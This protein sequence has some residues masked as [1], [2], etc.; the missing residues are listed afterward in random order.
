VEALAHEQFERLE[1]SHWWLRGRRTVYLGLLRHLL[2]G[3]RPG[4]AL[5]VGA[6][7]GGFSLGLAGLCD[8]VVALDRDAA[9]LAR[10]CGRSGARPLLADAAR[11]PFAEASFD[12]VC[13]F[14]VLEH[15]DDDAGA[16]RE[17]RRVLRPGGLLFASVPAWPFLYAHNDRVAHHRRRYRR[18]PLA[19]A[20]EAAGLQ[21]VRNTHTNAL[22]F[23]LI[24]PAVLAVKAWERLRGPRAGPHTNLSWPLP[25]GL[26]EL[27]YRAFAAELP[28]ARRLD[29]PA[30]HSIALAARRPPT[31]RAA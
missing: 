7:P 4:R 13:L 24:V 29:L 25:S 22:L 19:R 2:D 31:R 14:D 17:A 23:P 30:G 16:L 18:A 6:G 9:A 3:A 11:L 27:C 28:L 1:R 20:A 12:L 8:E 21:V 10:G 15:L 26:H 5:D